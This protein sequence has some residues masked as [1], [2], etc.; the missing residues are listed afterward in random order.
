MSARFRHL[1]RALLLA[2]CA[3]ACTT[4]SA[5]RQD[6]P[7][8]RQGSRSSVRVTLND[9]RVV[10]IRNASVRGDSIVGSTDR[11]GQVPIGVAHRDVRQL[12]TEVL[13][14]ARTGRALAIIAGALVIGFVLM[15]G[16][17]Y[18]SL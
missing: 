14:S 1:A 4:W 6:P 11:D 10:D 9:G 18:S 12:Q 5:P 3:A 2:W 13:D 15:I 16:Y 8:F 17:G 7:V